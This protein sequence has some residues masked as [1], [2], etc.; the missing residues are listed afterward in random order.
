VAGTEACPKQPPQHQRQ[1]DAGV[2]WK[3]GGGSGRGR[4]RN[5]QGCQVYARVLAVMGGAAWSTRLVNRARG[6]RS[7]MDGSGLSKRRWSLLSLVGEQDAV[8]EVC[9]VPRQVSQTPLKR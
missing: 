6:R 1:H 5:G 8:V 3:S 7:A 2:F 4:G 9:R